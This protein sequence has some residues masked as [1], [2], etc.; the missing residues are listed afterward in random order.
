MDDWC[1]SDA[2]QNWCPIKTLAPFLF[3]SPIFPD[4]TIEGGKWGGEG[5]DRVSDGKLWPPGVQERDGDEVAPFVGRACGELMLHTPLLRRLA[6]SLWRQR[7]PMRVVAPR[8]MLFSYAPATAAMRRLLREA[9]SSEQL[10]AKLR[11]GANLVQGG[12]DLVRGEHVQWWDGAT[13]QIWCARLVVMPC[14]SSLWWD[15]MMVPRLQ[16]ASH[17]PVLGASTTNMMSWV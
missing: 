14:T 8:S 1:L 9:S 11:R 3:P 7:H 5:G 2:K 10:R 17:D 13:P 6:S 12:P 16:S 15:T 4:H